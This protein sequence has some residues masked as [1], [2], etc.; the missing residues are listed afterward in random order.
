MLGWPCCVAS[1]L[2]CSR[3]VLQLQLPECGLRLVVTPCGVGN[4][5]TLCLFDA[6]A[7]HNIASQKHNTHT[8]THTHTLKTLLCTG[9]GG[10]SGGRP[11]LPACSHA[12]TA[13][14]LSRM[15]C[16]RALIS[17]AGRS[18]SRTDKDA[19]ALCR[20]NSQQQ[21]STAQRR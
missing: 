18:R 1:L 17:V 2:Y 11:F 14:I 13:S 10:Y 20:R 8:H 9:Y 19:L 21:H 3:R 15:P 4:T 5:I 16:L 7:K 6:K 12:A